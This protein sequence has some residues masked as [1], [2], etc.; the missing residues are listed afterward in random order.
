MATK[1]W[2]LSTLITR[3]TQIQAEIGDPDRRVVLEG[4][5]IKRFDDGAIEL[6]D[7]ETRRVAMEQNSQL[8]ARVKE[9]EHELT[10][11]G[12]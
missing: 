6:I 10:S 1:S 3:L 7:V 2:T 11:Y 8:Q 12:G 4:I 5:W 9:L